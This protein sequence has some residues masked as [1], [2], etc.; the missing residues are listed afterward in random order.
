MVQN[1]DTAPISGT[2][3]K[4]LSAT[5]SMATSRLVNEPDDAQVGRLL[6]EQ[7]AQLLDASD[8][9][10]GLL[11]PDPEWWVLRQAV[12]PATEHI[13]ERYSCNT[14]LL[15]RVMQMGA[16]FHSDRFRAHPLAASEADAAVLGSLV[17]VLLR[18]KGELLGALSASRAPGAPPLTPGDG[19]AL[20]VLADLGAAR[21]GAIPSV[22]NLRARAQDLASLDPV[23]RPP[24]HQAGDF[25][26]IT[27]SRDRPCLDVDDAACRILGYP[28]ERLLQRAI[29]DMIPLPPG[30][31]NVD[32][33][34]AVREQMIQ[35]IAITY[36]TIVRRRDGAIIPV[37]M[38]IQRVMSIQDRV[39]FRVT[40]SDLSR[41]MDAQLHTLEREKQRL[42]QEIGSAIAH[43]VNTPLAVVLG[44][45][46]M[47]LEEYT[48]PDA[49]MLLRPA[50]DGAVRISAAVQKLQRFAKLILPSTWAAV[51]LSR[52]AEEVVEKSRPI[53]DTAPRAEGRPIEL[54]V[55][56]VP[57]PVVRGNPKELLDAVSELLS[58]A[59]Q[60]M[61]HGGAIVVST[62]EQDGH[63]LLTV[64]DTGVGMNDEIRQRCIEPFF[65]TRRPAATGLGLN[66]VYHTVM[67]HR[68]RLAIESAEGAGTSVTINLPKAPHEGDVPDSAP[69]TGA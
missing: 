53:W 68:G 28:R 10:L 21:L 4:H 56:T 37:R 50:H 14:G 67:Q 39:I 3:P 48:D 30:S 20:Q 19:A 45:L 23:W 2:L 62:S 59:V 6:V 9:R 60:A 61:P 7:A 18:Y 17:A 34:A 41:E 47:M 36:D 55:Q 33:L 26:I 1:H 16:S 58:N 24:P 63:A 57:V 22:R 38:T 29:S 52:L 5:L 51:D 46:E 27:A 35:G 69:G 12:G 31:E 32:T 64:S 15:G 66:R 43:E 42:L 13:G 11:D 65:T 8:V 49:Q 44:N 40:F 25:V 54:A